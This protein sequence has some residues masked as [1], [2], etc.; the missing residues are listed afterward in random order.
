MP[1]YR[2]IAYRN[3]TNAALGNEGPIGYVDFNTE[4]GNALLGLFVVMNL[5]MLWA[6]CVC[7]NF[8]SAGLDLAYDAEVIY[9][10]LDGAVSKNE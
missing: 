1:N 3:V 9:K 2:A 8:G 10:T 4:D 6:I 5:F 7:W